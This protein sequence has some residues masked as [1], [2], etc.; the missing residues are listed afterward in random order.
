[1][2]GSSGELWPG[3]DGGYCAPMGLAEATHRNEDDPKKSA[4]QHHMNNACAETGSTK[5][6]AKIL[7]IGVPLLKAKTCIEVTGVGKG[8]GK[9]YCKKVIQEWSME[10]GYHT[11]ALLTRGEGGDSIPGQGDSVN[12]PPGK[13]TQ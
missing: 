13:V 6:Q 7:L 8:S 10:Q 3:A 1:M 11:Q 12:P 9:W 4:T 2:P 5:E